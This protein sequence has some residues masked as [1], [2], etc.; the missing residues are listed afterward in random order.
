MSP[1]LASQLDSKS[2]PAS[3][4]MVGAVWFAADNAVR[5]PGDS[6]HSSS[7]RHF[8]TKTPH[9]L[10]LYHR[11]LHNSQCKILAQVVKQAEPSERLCIAFFCGLAYNLMSQLTNLLPGLCSS[12]LRRQG[13]NTPFTRHSG[14]RARPPGCPR[15]PPS[16]ALGI[17]RPHI[18]VPQTDEGSCSAILSSSDLLPPPRGPPPSQ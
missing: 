16:P 12:F 4:S 13:F 6:W 5:P 2:L 15:T 7:A 14:G 11:I 1:S 18:V 8:P 10:Q 9:T 3:S 17:Y